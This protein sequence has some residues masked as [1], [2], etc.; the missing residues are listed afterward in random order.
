MRHGRLLIR[1]F[2]T[3][4]DRTLSLVVDASA[5]MAFSSEG[6]KTSKLA[7]ATLLAA[8]LA[9][10]ALAG[11]DPVALDWLGGE[12]VRP[13]R[14]MGGREAFERVVGA[15]ETARGSG[16]L[17]GNADALE[18]GLAPIGRRS[19][20]GSVI[21]LFSDLLDL[22]PGALDRFAGLGTRGRT[23]LAVRVLDPVEATFALS[24]PVR[25]RA[26]EG[27]RVIETNADLAR[28][29]YLEALEAIARQW[30]GRLVERGGHLVRATTNDDPV[31][32][33]RTILLCAQG[34][35]P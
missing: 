33:V 10:V 21:V 17:T 30:D 31:S 12:G 20:R 1:Q 24:G 34:G 29:D 35:A 32:I 16:D 9:R 2:E 14:A 6:A 23:L 28:A 13:L 25:L 5:S 19:A 15:L 7:Y 11:G 8:A 26:S 3:E 22:P 27:T 4:T 18:Q